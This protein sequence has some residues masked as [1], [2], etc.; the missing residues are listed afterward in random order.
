[1]TAKINVYG[2]VAL[3]A[4]VVPNS[5]QV[6]AQRLFCSFP[7]EDILELPVQS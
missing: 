1:L 2:K 3:A 5:L 7:L 4:V 6:I